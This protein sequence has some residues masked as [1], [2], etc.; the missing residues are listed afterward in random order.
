L[1]NSGSTMIRPKALL[2]GGTIGVVCP[3]KWAPKEELKAV[4]KIYES[5]GYKIKYGKSPFLRDNQFAG[6]PEERARDIE[7]MFPDPDVDAIVCARGGYGANRVIPLLDYNVIRQNPKIIMGYSD[8]TA[9][10][11]SINQQT[12]LIT[13]HGPMFVTYKQEFIPYNWEMWESI[14]SGKSHIEAT[15]PPDLKFNVLKP[16]VAS[17]LLMGGNLTLIANRLGTPGQVDF[18]D[19]I[20]FLEDIDEYLYAYD[21]YLVH[22]R[23]SGTVDKIKGLIVGEL[24]DIKDDTIPFGKTTDEIILD[25]FGDLDIPI[26]TNVACGHG[27]YQMTL[28]VSH[29][30]ALDVSSDSFFLSWDESPVT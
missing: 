20:L 2:K 18:D 6:T 3:S 24:E 21:R 10:L 12:G 4:Q 16:G 23:Q 14:V 17:G 25:V 11:H 9:L 22:L 8:I 1:S 29:P 28:P 27:K 30:V 15:N 5:H 19:S 13:F 26:V 7:K